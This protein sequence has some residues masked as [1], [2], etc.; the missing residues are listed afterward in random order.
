MCCTSTQLAQSG[1]KSFQ[2][3]NRKRTAKGNVFFPNLRGA[4]PVKIC[5]LLT[6]T[7]TKKP[8]KDNKSTGKKYGQRKSKVIKKELIS[9]LT[10]L[11]QHKASFPL[12][13]SILIWELNLQKQLPIEKK[14]KLSL[15]KISNEQKS[16]SSDI[17]AAQSQLRYC[18]RKSKGRQ[19]GQS[20]NQFCCFTCGG[21]PVMFLDPRK[22]L[23]EDPILSKYFDH[24]CQKKI[25]THRFC[26]FIFLFNIVR[27][28]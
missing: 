17:A 6:V 14:K 4:F 25:T 10:C 2:Q 21:V 19:K 23:S 24:N 13:L 5:M 7:H 1:L 20:C 11:V 16:P 8:V 22:T 18:Q 28:I 12:Q 27:K 3:K 9:K 15:K 26:L